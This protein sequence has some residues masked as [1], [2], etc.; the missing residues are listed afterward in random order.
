MPSL[1]GEIQERESKPSQGTK[2]A[3]SSTPRGTPNSATGFPQAQ[4]RSKS[5]FARAREARRN[6][7]QKPDQIPVVEPSKG[8]PAAE[9][10]DV[11]MTAQPD[12]I[13]EQW[14]NDISNQNEKRVHLMSE[15]ER[16]RE[17]EDIIE[18]FGPEILDLMQ[19]IKRR[20]DAAVKSPSIEDNA[21]ALFAAEPATEAPVNRSVSENIEVPKPRIIIP[22]D[23][24]EPPLH[25][26]QHHARPSSPLPPALRSAAGTPLPKA[27]GRK[28]RFSTEPSEVYVYESAPSSPKR[29]PLALLGAPDPDDPAPNQLTYRGP[30][31]KD[32]ATQDSVAM[33]LISPTDEPTQSY[34]TFPTPTTTEDQIE[35]GTPEDIRKRFFPNADSDNPSLE[36]IKGRDQHDGTPAESDSVTRGEQLA[37]K[38]TRY[39]LNGQPIPESLRKTLPTHLGLHHHGEEHDEAGYTLEELLMLSRSTVPAQRASIL[40]TLGKLLSNAASQSSGDDNPDDVENSRTKVLVIAL[41]ALAERGGALVRAVEVLWI[42]T[43]DYARKRPS[44]S[45]DFTNIAPLSTLLRQLAVHLLPSA[46]ELPPE[47]LTQLLEFLIFLASSPA[48]D[49]P[50]PDEIGSEILHTRDLIP[51]ILHTF[52]TSTSSDIPSWTSDS[53]SSSRSLAPNADAITLVDALAQTSRTNAKTIVENGIADTFMKFVVVLPSTLATDGTKDV[54]LAQEL[55]AR[56]LDLYATLGQYGMYAITAT[57][58]ADAFAALGK[59][60]LDLITPDLLD[61]KTQKNGWLVV[62]SYLKLVEVW[63]TCAIDPHKTTP[64]H[65]ILWSQVVGWDWASQVFQVRQSLL[66]LLG[67][68]PDPQPEVG[69]GSRNIVMREVLAA[70]WHALSAWLEGSAVNSVKLGEFE[71]HQFVEKMAIATAR[72]V[73]DL[74]LSQI[75]EE[76]NRSLE[77]M[78]QKQ[79]LGGQTLE[80]LSSSGMALLSAMRLGLASLPPEPSPPSPPPYGPLSKSNFNTVLTL[81]NKL[82]E[83]RIWDDLRSLPTSR[84]ILLRPLSNL[85]AYA[86]LAAR[87]RGALELKDWLKLAFTSMTCLIEGDEELGSRVLEAITR[88]ITKAAIGKLTLSGDK[89]VWSDVSPELWSQGGMQIIL[90]FLQTALRRTRVTSQ[91]GGGEDEEGGP[92]NDESPLEFI[93]PLVIG[94]NSIQEATTLRLPHSPTSFKGR[95]S[96]PRGSGHGLPLQR[97]WTFA[98]L[99]AL[100]HSS[101]AP[102]FTIL[103]SDWDHSEV[104]VVRA[105]LL[106]TRI[107]QDNMA[108]KMTSGFASDVRAVP[109]SREEVVFGC[110]KVFMLEHGQNSSSSFGND[111]AIEVFRDAMVSQEMDRLLA[112]FRSLGRSANPPPASDGNFP[113]SL[114]KTALPYLGAATP[115][116]Q[117]YSD[118]LGLYDSISFGHPTFGSLLIPPLANTTYPMDYRK[119]LWGDYAHVLRHLSMEPAD[120]IGSDPKDWLYP[121]ESDGELIGMYVKAL[122]NNRL[123]GFLR[124]VAVHHIASNIWPDL[125]EQQPPSF[126]VKAKAMDTEPTDLS[127]QSRLTRS[128]KLL[129]AVLGNSNLNGVKEVVLYYQPKPN[130]NPALAPPMCFEDDN[131][132]SW[133]QQRLEWVL[134][135]GGA[136]LGGR[137]QAL[138]SV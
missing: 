39:D 120:V 100:L 26:P 22:D 92:G 13:E 93:A 98:P 55:L 90:P 11:H 136:G 102:V 38:S 119:L 99:D 105:T 33:D 35:E 2:D 96:T 75:A 106:L 118:F 20:R 83:N 15:S 66:E 21:P 97:D 6:G 114:E 56:T 19:R 88:S 59:Y 80:S 135:W 46:Q 134:A 29:Q 8:S 132:G 49:N 122:G 74:I 41:E 9:P 68:D 121:V 64:P 73:E 25:T 115:F 42:S 123:R 69:G 82:A 57:T 116:F 43:V 63:T 125:Q 7:P 76:M 79:F 24:T 108:T 28:P 89:M 65:E 31:I 36:W 126:G 1:V 113:P 18:R 86:T 103:P 94:R 109:I 23:F 71:R 27:P 44:S 58:A 10:A 72:P 112:P 48:I 77:S 17:R 62:T 51:S 52:V 78:R 30:D 54:D 85:L 128:R 3:S 37:R 81:C 110:M 47:S 61:L 124:W 129:Q 130:T 91:D 45:L 40:G 138:L 104:D 131:T 67:S 84:I 101:T 16:E 133:K 137:L 4:H 32:S 111:S 50:T 127:Q 70:V 34:H 53:S 5:A 12:A 95:S 14:R 107:L 60:V 87:R 117:F